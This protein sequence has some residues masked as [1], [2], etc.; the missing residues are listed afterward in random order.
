MTSAVLKIRT[1]RRFVKQIKDMSEDL[2]KRGIMT[3]D[4]M[5]EYARQAIK[6]KL[7]ADTKALEDE[8]A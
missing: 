5:S 4:S 8:A 1:N 3:S 7:E 6:D 2:Y